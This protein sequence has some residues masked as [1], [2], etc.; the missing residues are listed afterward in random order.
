MAPDDYD[1]L[2]NVRDSG[3][4]KLAD[5]IYADPV[6]RKEQRKKKLTRP[7]APRAEGFLIE[8]SESGLHQ[9]ITPSE[10]ARYIHKDEKGIKGILR[11]TKSKGPT[12][13]KKSPP[14]KK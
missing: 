7:F 8:E 1:A 3:F 10:A 2:G 9:E 5:G 11:F 4:S 14:R 6:R 12:E 13:K